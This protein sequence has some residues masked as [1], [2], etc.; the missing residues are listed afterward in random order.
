METPEGGWNVI[1]GADKEKIIGA[2]RNIHQAEMQKD[3][4]GRA[5]VS[6][7]ILNIL[8]IINKVI[9]DEHQI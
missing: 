4:F 6:G 5:E 9:Y 1:V 7:R 8:S 2:M 3:I